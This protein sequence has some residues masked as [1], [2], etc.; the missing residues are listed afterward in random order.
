MEGQLRK[1]KQ[2]QATVEKKSATSLSTLTKILVQPIVFVSFLI[3]N[4]GNMQR[5]SFIVW[6]KFLLFCCCIAILDHRSFEDGMFYFKIFFL[7]IL[8]HL[9]VNCSIT[10][11]PIPVGMDN[12]Q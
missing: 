5:E 11:N 8:F 12:K 3:K 9:V 4:V 2:A 7:L 1:L 6:I 10:G